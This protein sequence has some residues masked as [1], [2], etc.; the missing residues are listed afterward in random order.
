MLQ[1]PNAALVGPAVRSWFPKLILH[2]MKLLTPL[3]DGVHS[4]ADEDPDAAAAAGEMEAPLSPLSVETGGGFTATSAAATGGGGGGGGA[5]K[6]ERYEE[7]HILHF[8]G[9]AHVRAW[10]QWKSLCTPMTVPAST[11]TAAV[12]LQRSPTTSSSSHAPLSPVGPT[13]A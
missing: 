11:S 9:E 12:A 7:E 5:A 6:I 1:K 3:V 4:Q 2:Q 8:I 13:S 10:R